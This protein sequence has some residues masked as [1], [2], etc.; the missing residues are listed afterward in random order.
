MVTRASDE[1]ICSAQS[2]SASGS[3]EGT[4]KDRIS[5]R[6]QAQLVTNRVILKEHVAHSLMLAAK[7]AEAGS[8]TSERFCLCDAGGSGC[9]G[10]EIRIAMCH[11]CFL[12]YSCLPEEVRN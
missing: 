11:G 12:T 8:V 6:K 4:A 3:R 2:P 5:S 9:L 10:K 7:T 1:N